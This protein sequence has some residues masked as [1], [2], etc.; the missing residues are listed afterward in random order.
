MSFLHVMD[1]AVWR[2]TAIRNLF[3]KRMCGAMSFGERCTAQE[4]SGGLLR[5]WETLLAI[6]SNAEIAAIINK[7]K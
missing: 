6:S 1:A 5:G 4:Q 7:Y 3:H 2:G